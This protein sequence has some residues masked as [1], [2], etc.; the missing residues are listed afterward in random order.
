MQA[1]LYYVFIVT[2]YILHMI[3]FRKLN[4]PVVLIGAGSMALF[5]AA[6]YE[7]SLKQTH[8][9]GF[10][11][12]DTD[13]SLRRV[14]K[15][16]VIPKMMKKLAKQEECVSEIE[17]FNQCCKK[18]KPKTLDSFLTFRR[19]K[20]ES[21]VMMECLNNKFVDFDYYLKCKKIYMKDKKLFVL[22]KVGKKEREMIKDSVKEGKKPAGEYTEDL[23]NYY[24]NVK[25]SFELTKDIDAYDCKIL[26]ASDHEHGF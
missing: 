20:E 3:M 25:S 26:E 18:Y 22:T 11:L 16:V 15:D 24:N 19:C 4:T 10:H 17:H 12:K 8:S 6:I 9:T 1:V 23:E 7:Y 2:A 5:G 21:Q 13:P 14:E